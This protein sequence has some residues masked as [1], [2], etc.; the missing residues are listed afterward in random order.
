MTAVTDRQ[1][2]IGIETTYGTYVA[3]TLFPLVKDFDIIEPPPATI[4]WG[5]IR[6]GFFARSDGDLAFGPRVG[7]RA[8]WNQAVTAQVASANPITEILYG[9]L[10]GKAQSGTDPLTETITVATLNGRSYSLQA[11]KPYV[12]GSGVVVATALGSKITRLRLSCDVGGPMRMM[13]EADVRQVTEAQSKAAATYVAAAPL[14]WHL[15]TLTIN[16][17]AVKIKG[18]D[19]DI[20]NPLVYDRTYLTSG[21]LKDEP[22]EG[23]RRTYMLTLRGVE[24]RD[25]THW[26]RVMA[27]TAATRMFAVSFETTAV[28][29]AHKLTLT[30]SKGLY[31]SGPISGLGVEQFHHEIP[32]L[33]MS[34]EQPTD[35]SSPITLAYVHPA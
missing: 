17:S 34:F 16:S 31:V 1:F 23:G 18:W 33:S 29:T 5:G 9:A 13:V 8:V 7:G 12:D 19:L 22:L 25:T 14:L 27:T 20:T 26:A 15:S 4:D 10:G 24:F 21:G 6:A 35:G 3:P 30:G 2:G 28:N 11:V 32:S